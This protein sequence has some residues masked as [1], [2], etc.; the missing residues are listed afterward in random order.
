MS[1]LSACQS[2]S[3]KLVGR[4][5]K[6]VYSITDK[7]S[8]ELGDLANEV[9]RD[10]AKSHDWQALIKIHEIPSDGVLYEFPLPDNF[11]RTTVTAEMVSPYTDVFRFN[12]VPDVTEFMKATAGMAWA[13]PGVWTLYGKRI[14]FFPAPIEP[15][16]LPYVS[17]RIVTTPSG[18]EKAEFTKDNDIFILS[19]R[20]LMLGLV[21]RW[22]EMKR[23][24]YG[25]DQAAF[26]K[27]IDEDAG[28][29]KGARV[30]VVGC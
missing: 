19:E 6:G 23:L 17:N 14:R 22:R 11:D 30:V 9:A 8:L 26:A 15:L 12:H 1:I 16:K 13:Y 21:W 2:A 25:P 10:I 3:V 29:D 27:A 4:K 18:A 28:R 5:V 20:L 24:D 7:L